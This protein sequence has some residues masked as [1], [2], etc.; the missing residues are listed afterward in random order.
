MIPSDVQ[1]D[2]ANCLTRLN[3]RSQVIASKQ[4]VIDAGRSK[5]HVSINASLKLT[6]FYSRAEFTNDSLR[7]HF[8]HF[9]ECLCLQKI[10]YTRWGRLPSGYTTACIFSL[11][12]IDQKS[13]Q[14]P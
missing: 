3:A 4:S 7:S 11:Q 5:A 13:P 6:L 8:V 10:L 9:L 14:N 12:I 1:F 2:T